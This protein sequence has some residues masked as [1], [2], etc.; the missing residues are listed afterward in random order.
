M[1]RRSL[2]PSIETTH[3]LLSVILKMLKLTGREFLEVCCR[4]VNADSMRF[5]LCSGVG[6]FGTHLAHNFL[7]KKRKENRCSMTILYKEG[8]IYGK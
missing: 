6:C 8:E 1:C 5:A 3:L 7:K 2:P 4:N